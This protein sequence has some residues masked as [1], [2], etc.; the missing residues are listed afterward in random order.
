MASTSAPALQHEGLAE[1][2]DF[3]RRRPLSHNIHRCRHRR[4]A[5]SQSR[6]I[7]IPW[8]EQDKLYGGATW[9]D[10]T[11]EEQQEQADEPAERAPQ[12]TARRGKPLKIN[13]DLLLVRACVLLS[14][15]GCGCVVGG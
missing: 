3:S 8:E 1:G 12:Q 10:W 14:P 11:Y 13:R 15:V 9:G 6:A 2:I 7:A 5:A 4:V